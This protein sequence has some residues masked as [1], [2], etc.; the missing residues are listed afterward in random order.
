MNIERLAKIIYRCPTCGEIYQEEFGVYIESQIVAKLDA[1]T[2]CGDNNL[3]QLEE[4]FFT[5]DCKQCEYFAGE[6]KQV[7][8]R[9]LK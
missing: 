8:K 9:D 3:W 2:T 4:H 1:C 6:Y 5:C 7:F